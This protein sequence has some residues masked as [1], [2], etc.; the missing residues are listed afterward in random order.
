MEQKHT[1]HEDEELYL[2][3]DDHV[4]KYGDGNCACTFFVL[5]TYDPSTI[6]FLADLAVAVF[7]P[8][9]FAPCQYTPMNLLLFILLYQ[10]LRRNR[11]SRFVTPKCAEYK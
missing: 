11:S 9:K 5:T 8:Q 6:R 1:S 2:L 10:V 3:C 4:V 7:G